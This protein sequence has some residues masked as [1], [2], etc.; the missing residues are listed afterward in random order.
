[1]E[2]GRWK[3]SLLRHTEFCLC[4]AALGRLSLPYLVD[5]DEGILDI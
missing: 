1:M 3:T 2:D 5:E 4:A